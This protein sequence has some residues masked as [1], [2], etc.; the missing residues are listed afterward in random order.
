MP[1]IQLKIF[2]LLYFPLAEYP[3][4][5]TLGQLIPIILFPVN[6]VFNWSVTKLNLIYRNDSGISGFT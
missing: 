1:N 4:I 2:L 3:I 6:C 5:V